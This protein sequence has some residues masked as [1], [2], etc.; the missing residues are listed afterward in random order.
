MVMTD[1]TYDSN[2]KCPE[3]GSSRLVGWYP[4]LEVANSAVTG[5]LCDI[6]ETCYQYALIEE[7]EV[8]LYH[9][10]YKRWWYKYDRENDEYIPIDE[11][12]FIKGFCGF[13]IG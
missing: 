5:N 7:C 12:S 11:P 8:G 6:N 4:E 13:T 10:A 2:T 3:F 1:L 9:P